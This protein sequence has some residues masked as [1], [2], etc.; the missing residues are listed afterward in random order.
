MDAPHT[1]T[2]VVA[3]AY[4]GGV[5]VGADSRVSMGTYINNRASNKIT[6]LTDNVWLLRSGSA[7]DAQAVADYGEPYWM[8]FALTHFLQRMSVSE[9][10][11]CSEVLGKQ[12]RH[13]SRQ[14]ALCAICGQPREAGKPLARSPSFLGSPSP[15]CASGILAPHYHMSH[16]SP[17]YQC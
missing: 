6:P 16:D 15:L 17:V 7:A 2:T 1:G 3:V 12:S 13:R 4:D 5:V 11:R 10:A 14:R 8:C 9:H